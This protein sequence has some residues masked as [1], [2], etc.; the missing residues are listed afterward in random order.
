MSAPD[1]IPL[2]NGK[3][4]HR[5]EFNLTG[6][7]I[8]LALVVFAGVRCVGAF[9]TEAFLAA[10]ILLTLGLFQ[11]VVTNPDSPR[12]NAS[13]EKLCRRRPA[14]APIFLLLYWI[15]IALVEPFAQVW[16]PFTLIYSIV[17]LVPAVVGGLKVARRGMWLSGLGCWLIMFSAASI[18]SHNVSHLSKK[19][20]FFATTWD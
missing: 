4:M 2:H 6:C 12:L 9:K 16:S 14:S 20:G 1:A 19:I 7:G 18:L 15:S 8:G 17:F 3:L 5:V 11:K 10:G 13:N